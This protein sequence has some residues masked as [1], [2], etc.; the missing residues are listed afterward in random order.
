MAPPLMKMPENMK[1]RMKMWVGVQLRARL[2]TIICIQGL[3]FI[4][5]F[6]KKNTDF[7]WRVF[8]GE[9]KKSLSSSTF[10]VSK[11]I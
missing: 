3:V 11:K 8:V 4:L 7:G 9:E 2:S 10:F 1:M 6:E 5:D